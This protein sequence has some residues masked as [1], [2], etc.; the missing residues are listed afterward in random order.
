MLIG[1]IFS[2][3]GCG[4]AL[5]AR[6][7][8][9]PVVLFP[10]TKDEPDALSP[11]SLVATLRSGAPSRCLL[12]LSSFLSSLVMVNVEPSLVEPMLEIF[13]LL[14]SLAKSIFCNPY[15]LLSHIHP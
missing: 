2:I 14:L 15:R 12:S 7:M 1:I 9:I 6:E 4:G 3:S 10:K 5:Y 11:T 13:F 8:G